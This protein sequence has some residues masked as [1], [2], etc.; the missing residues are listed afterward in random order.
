MGCALRLLPLLVL[1]PTIALAEP[2]DAT[3][4][5]LGVA[6]VS[7]LVI[8]WGQTRD[9]VKRPHDYE[10]RNPLLGKHPSMGRVNLICAGSIA[11]T[12]LT[13]DWLTSK[14]RKIFLGTITAIELTVIG[15]NK[16]IGLRVSF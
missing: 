11:A 2:W 12:L 10:E 8:D 1:A 15:H 13:A 16:N 4:R 3:D 14:N 5:A 9:I 6:A 7:A